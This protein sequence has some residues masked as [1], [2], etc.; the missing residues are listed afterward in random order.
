M[1]LCWVCVVV[2]C[3]VYLDFLRMMLVMCLV[4]L[5]LVRVCVV[6]VICMCWVEFLDNLCSM[7][8]RCV[9]SVL[10]CFSNM[11]VLCLIRYFVLWV[12]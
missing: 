6:L 5:I 11:V 9:V 8:C 7:F 4:V 3:G 2:W 1:V 12:W 10:F